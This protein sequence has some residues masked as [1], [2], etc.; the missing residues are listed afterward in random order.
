MLQIDIHNVRLEPGD[1]CW[2]W[3]EGDDADSELRVDGIFDRRRPA[4]ARHP[5][6]Y[7]MKGQS[8]EGIGWDYCEKI[9]EV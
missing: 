2:F 8:P 6:E 7:R 1:K 3:D 9:N 5:A 4:T